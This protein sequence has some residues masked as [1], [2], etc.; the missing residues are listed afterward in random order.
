MRIAGNSEYR[1]SS[2]FQ[3]A[4]ST[5]LSPNSGCRSHIGHLTWALPHPVELLWLVVVDSHELL[6]SA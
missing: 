6:P 3:M 5:T 4:D 1:G 2:G